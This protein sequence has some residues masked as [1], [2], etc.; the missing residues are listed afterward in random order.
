[1]K[2]AMKYIVIYC[3]AIISIILVKNQNVNL[4]LFLLSGFVGMIINAVEA[5]RFHDFMWERYPN[6]YYE[7]KSCHGETRNWLW[8]YAED[9]CR[10]DAT[11]DPVLLE[12]CRRYVFCSY[13]FTAFFISLPIAVVIHLESF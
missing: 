7:Y 5:L 2:Q 12:N 11:D 10:K 1:M 13:S 6:A 3:V 4:V 9:H 8:E